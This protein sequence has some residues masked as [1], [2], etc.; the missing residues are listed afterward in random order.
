MKLF[1]RENGEGCPLIILHGLYGSSDNWMS[2]ARTLGNHF[3]VFLPD[4]RNHG[5]SPH[6][7][8]HA[9][10]ALSEDLAEFIS[11]HKIER[12]VIIGHS[13]GGKTAM[14]LAASYP[15]LIRALIV[16]DIS[17]GAYPSASGS[18]PGI[19][20]HTDIIEILYN[21]PV[22]NFSTREEAEAG[23]AKYIPYNRVRQFLLKNLTR[24]DTGGFQWK[25]NIRALKENFH[26]IF[27]G[28]DIPG[29][30]SGDYPVLFIKGALSEYITE[31]DVALIK[32]LYPHA[33]IKNIEGAGHWVHAEKPGELMDAIMEFLR[34]NA[35]C[36]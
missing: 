15:E 27:A 5:Q 32:E 7:N 23:L 16:I 25:I 21:L 14:F 9:Y 34:A 19:L 22:E 4:Q 33:V 31:K 13:M 1:Y 26:N 24:G 35:L 20:N 3:R 8:I 28:L 29:G 30:L 10:E 36:S 6:S 18:K 11:E 12:P 2:F 17:P